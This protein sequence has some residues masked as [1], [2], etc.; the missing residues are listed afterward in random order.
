MRLAG[1]GQIVARELR[2]GLANWTSAEQIHMTLKF[3][4][5]V[6]RTEQGRVERALEEV[7]ARAQPFP[8]QARALGCFPNEARPRVIWAGMAGVLGILEQA[9]NALDS[10]LA[11]VVSVEDERPLRPHLTIGRFKDWRATDREPLALAMSRWA[12]TEFGTW[13]VDRL[14]LVQSALG[15]AGS[16]YAVLKSCIFGA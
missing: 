6:E 3:L 12:D 15:P 7:A 9:K 11:G 14:D 2:P 8:I 16:T 4:G 10:R 13:T 5:A 1:A